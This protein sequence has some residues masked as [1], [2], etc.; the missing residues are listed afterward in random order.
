[1]QKH[2]NLAFAFVLALAACALPIQVPA[3]FAQQRNGGSDFVAATADEA[4]L[5]VR[6]VD[7]PTVGSDAKFWAETLRNEFVEQ[8]GY[9]EVARG[10]VADGAGVEGH[11]VEFTANVQGEKVDYLAAVWSRRGGLFDLGSPY[12][13]VV[14]FAARGAAYASRIEAVKAALKTVRE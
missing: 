6:E 10:A 4:V 7:D 13:Q 1:M 3:D 14:E 11:W 8:R 12:V 9:V 5:R 2:T